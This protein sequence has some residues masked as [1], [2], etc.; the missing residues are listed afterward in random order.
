MILIFSLSQHM[1]GG[2]SDINKQSEEENSVYSLGKLALW[3]GKFT[4]QNQ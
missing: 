4:Q 1:T 3:F 2:A